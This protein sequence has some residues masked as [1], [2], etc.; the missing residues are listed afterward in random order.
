MSADLNSLFVEFRKEKL[1]SF[2]NGNPYFALDS[3]ELSKYDRDGLSSFEELGEYKLEDN[4]RVL[5]TVAISEKVLNERSSRKLQYDISKKILTDYPQYHAGLFVYHDE[6]G[7]FRLSLVYKDF[8]GTRVKLSIYR[9]FSYFVEK[10]KGNKTFKDRIGNLDFKNLPELKE[11]FSVDKVTKE[12]FKIYREHYFSIVEEFENNSVFQKEVIEK[13]D[14]HTADFVKKLMGQIVF[15]YFLQRKGWLG[16][17]PGAEWGT[18]DQHFVRTLFESCR[19]Q[20]KNFYNDYL[21]PL[22][23]DCLGNA[24]RGNRGATNDQSFSPQFNVRIPYLNGGLFEDEYDWKSTNVEIANEVFEKLL[25]FFEQYNFTVDENTPSDQEVSVDPEM[26]GKIFENLLEIKDRKSKGS[27]YTPREIVHYMCRESLVNYLISNSDIPEERI[28]NLFEAKDSE[29]FVF[30]EDTKIEKIRNLEDLKVIA[31]KVN[32]LLH[33]IKI[34]DPAVGSGAFPM[35]MLSEISST[36]WYLYRNFLQSNYPKPVSLYDIKRETLENCIYGVDIDPGAVEIAKLRFWLALVVEHNI[37]EVEA[38]PNL[39]YKIMQGNSL[40]EE[41]EGI[42]IFDEKL[43]EALVINA[44]MFEADNEKILKLQSELLQKYYIENP[45]WLRSKTVTRPDEVRDLEKELYKLMKKKKKVV[46]EHYEQKDLFSD[47]APSSQIRDELESLHKRFFNETNL[48]QKKDLKERIERLEWELIETTL[49]EQGKTAALKKL[50]EF[51]RLNTKPFF[52]WKLNFADVF[53]GKGGFDI[54]IANPPYKVILKNEDSFALLKKQFILSR[55]GKMN[56]YRLFFEKGF[57]LL[58]HNGVLSYISP[59]NYLTSKDSTGF[60]K[61]LIENH[62][63]LSI[64]DYTEKDK[65]FENVAQAVA[66][67]VASNQYSPEYK[68]LFTQYGISH[69]LSSGVITQKEGCFIKPL[70][71]IISKIESNE[72]KLSDFADGYQGEVNVSLKKADFILN[73][74]EGYFPL[75]RGNNIGKFYLKK[76]IAEYC[77]ASVQRRDHYKIIDRVIFQAISNS[78]QLSR[79]NGTILSKEVLCGHSTNYLFPIRE[80]VSSC[81]LLGLI[82]S[83][84]FNFYF[85]FYNQTNNVPIGEIKKIPVPREIP[86]ETKNKIENLVAEILAH[87]SS[88]GGTNYLENEV[89]ELV[90]NLYQL[91]GEEKDIIKSS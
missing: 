6:T 30:V 78:G 88:E 24:D 81:F 64:I 39:D 53:K 65:V 61:L 8:E 13:H 75:I 71:E 18:G 51:K 37:G 7:N 73:P 23:Y 5:V 86:T 57:S 62:T 10:G 87:K 3:K 52:L 56:L 2:F 12:F 29:L 82:N 40:L 91:S 68:F 1:L 16:V 50:E 80:N 28:R 17:R 84:L 90:F 79:I 41:F 55:G 67:I 44:S 36:R 76:E 63:V 59:D 15:L 11:L 45:E 33:D 69:Q 43:L 77:P 22:F 32:K 27:Y 58:T 48:T 85:K 47:V 60:R 34:V 31:E 70:P 66:V 26:L 74:Q 89:D 9:R 46:N 38:L 25:N 35:G 54:V 21:E 42:K 49:K 14:I 4:S 83:R 19:E 72:G 20:R